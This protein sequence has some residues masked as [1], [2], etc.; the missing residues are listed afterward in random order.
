MPESQA[1]CIA[2]NVL[3]PS[4]LLIAHASGGKDG[5][6]SISVEVTCLELPSANS[7]RGPLVISQCAP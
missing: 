1:R 3:L 2:S 7:T 4:N 6:A 5:I